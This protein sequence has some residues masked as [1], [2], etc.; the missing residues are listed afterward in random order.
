MPSTGWRTI[1]PGRHGLTIDAL[2]RIPAWAVRMHDRSSRLKMAHSRSAMTTAASMSASLSFDEIE[3]LGMSVISKAHFGV[4]IFI[5]SK[6]FRIATMLVVRGDVGEDSLKSRF[7]LKS[8]LAVSIPRVPSIAEEISTPFTR[9]ATLSGPTCSDSAK[10][11]CVPERPTSKIANAILMDAIGLAQ[12]SAHVDRC[13][14][15]VVQ[16][17]EAAFAIDDIQL[18]FQIGRVSHS[19]S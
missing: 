15:A 19:S 8:P 4:G 9:A 12:P 1:V 2:R 5:G 14:D 17:D 13:H 7:A 11:S 6:V 16:K 18:T 10:A 3:T